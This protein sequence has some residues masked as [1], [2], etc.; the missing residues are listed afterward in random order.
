[1]IIAV[2][3]KGRMESSCNTSQPSRTKDIASSGDL[4]RTNAF[5]SAPAM[6]LSFAERITSPFGLSWRMALSAE[7][8]SS[9][10]WREKVLADSPCLSK[11][12]QARPWASFSQ[13]QCANTIFGSALSI[14][15]LL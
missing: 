2:V 7:P 5:T 4:K 12:S 14:V 3:G 10:A 1:L 13:R 6:K 15:L 11:V 9:S 8:S